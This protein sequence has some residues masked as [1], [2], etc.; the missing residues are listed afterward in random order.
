MNRVADVPLV[1]YTCGNLCV[2]ASRLITREA[3]VDGQIVGFLKTDLIL[4]T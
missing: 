3:G 2:V 1:L 4:M